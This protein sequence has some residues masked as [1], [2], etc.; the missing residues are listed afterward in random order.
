MSQRPK[1]SF[2]VAHLS[3]PKTD[4]AHSF[5]QAVALASAASGGL[6]AFHASDEFEA[7]TIEEK[8]VPDNVEFVSHTTNGDEL[9]AEVHGLR[10]QLVVT[11]TH[12]VHGLER[13]FKG[14]HA[15][16]VARGVPH[17][18]LFLGVGDAGLLQSDGSLAIRR[19]LLPSNDGPREARAIRG[20]LELCAK[21]GIPQPEFVF[22]GIGDHAPPANEL[23]HGVASTSIRW[24][25]FH[26][27]G[28][29][30]PTIAEF[31]NLQHADLIVMVTD[32]RD[33]L[34]DEVLGSVTERVVRETNRPV[35]SIPNGPAA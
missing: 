16:R 29:I 15:G 32:G 5:E 23:P 35:L 21:L 28:E 27:H 4:S 6:V 17:P 19:V 10:P 2:I 1:R 24:D 12:R 13:L 33:S 14:S 34:E 3:D 26:E 30:A 7:G 25:R 11:A 22:L 31:A 18:T 20:T 8:R 9:L